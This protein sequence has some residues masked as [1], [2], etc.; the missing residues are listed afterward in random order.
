MIGL[1]RSAQS[2]FSALKKDEKFPPIFS[3]VQPGANIAQEVQDESSTPIFVSNP[4]PPQ[5]PRPKTSV[6]VYTF[7]LSSPAT[8]ADDSGIPFLQ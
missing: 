8:L 5:V 6:P 1:A 7:Q 3:N 2:I 4:P